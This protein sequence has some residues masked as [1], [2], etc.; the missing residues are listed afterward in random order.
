MLHFVS[1]PFPL[2]RKLE[3]DTF[4]ET[5]TPGKKGS[6]PFRGIGAEGSL[7]KQG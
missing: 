6:T 1:C 5:P 3:C 7:K 4:C 2:P